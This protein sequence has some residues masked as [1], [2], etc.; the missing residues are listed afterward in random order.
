MR[1]RRRQN[2]EGRGHKA[3]KQ[4]TRLPT[5][6]KNQKTQKKTQKVNANSKKGSGV[7]LRVRVGDD[8]RRHRSLQCGQNGLFFAM[9][10][11]LC[12]FL[13]ALAPV[14]V[15]AARS[16][17]PDQNNGTLY[18]VLQRVEAV[19]VEMFLNGTYQARIRPDLFLSVFNTYWDLI[20]SL[21]CLNATWHRQRTDGKRLWV[22][23]DLTDD[24]Q[25]CLD[26]YA[27]AGP[28]G[29]CGW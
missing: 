8:D 18:S 11:A 5:D 28:P 4:F 26:D 23:V 1:R 9:K 20:D 27:E 16:R 29:K 2:D 12:L 17:Q 10:W 21:C 22:A 25:L 24:Q 14:T 19:G 7:K 15:F 3:T 13:L 6:S